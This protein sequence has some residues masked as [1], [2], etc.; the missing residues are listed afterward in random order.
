MSGETVKKNIAKTMEI[1][2]MFNMFDVMSYIAKMDKGIADKEA[3]LEGLKSMKLAYEEELEII[4]KELGIKK[5]QAEWEKNQAEKLAA[6]P[7]DE[8][9]EEA[10]IPTPYNEENI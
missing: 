6:Q 7:K 5:K 8:T 4:E 9:A 2:E 10:L 1:T 3:E